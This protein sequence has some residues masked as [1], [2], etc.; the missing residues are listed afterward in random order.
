M[1]N[2]N[3]YRS[4]ISHNLLDFAKTN[5]PK[6]P[7]EYQTPR[8]PLAPISICWALSKCRGLASILRIFDRKAI[9]DVL[10]APNYVHKG[11]GILVNSEARTGRVPCALA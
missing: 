9:F 3:G 10:L 2:K 7:N 1:K 11:V 8:K 6:S 5:T 4:I